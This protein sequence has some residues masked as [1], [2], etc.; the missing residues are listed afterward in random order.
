MPQR[1]RQLSVD[2]T[3]SLVCQYLAKQRPAKP[4]SSMPHVEGS[5]T[6]VTGVVT[7]KTSTVPG[8]GGSLLKN[9]SSLL[10]EQPEM[11]HEIS[12]RS[13]EST[14]LEKNISREG[15]VPG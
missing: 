4:T 10:K 13:K 7:E 12:P 9:F 14:P 5:G 11:L 2:A 3:R 15:V 6:G 1:G 8:T